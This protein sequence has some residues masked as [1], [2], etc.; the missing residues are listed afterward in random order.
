LSCYFKILLIFIVFLFRK[1]VCA[2]KVEASWR[3]F[4]Q[5]LNTCL[6]REAL[7]ANMQS[8]LNTIQG[9]ILLIFH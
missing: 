2:D 5:S 1:A 7:L 8:K 6:A 9:E 4:E 3:K